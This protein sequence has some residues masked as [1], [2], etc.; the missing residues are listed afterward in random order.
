MLYLGFFQFLYHLKEKLYVFYPLILKSKHLKKRLE[1]LHLVNMILEIFFRNSKYPLYTKNTE[2]E[3][4]SQLHC[5]FW[6]FL[7]EVLCQLN[8]KPESVLV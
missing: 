8:L 4:I 6:H 5:F 1:F 7:G 3:K 2:N